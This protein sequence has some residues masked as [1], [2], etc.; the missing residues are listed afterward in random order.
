MVRTQNPD[1]CSVSG[2]KIWY[3]YGMN[4]FGSGKSLK[5]TSP[6]LRDDAERHMRILDV[7]E[8]DSVIEGLPP[9]S[10]ETRE[11]LRKQLQNIASHEPVIEPAE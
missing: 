8:R 11:K 7:A 5:E 10:D 9:F 1:N 2:Q 4:N 3:N 6:Q